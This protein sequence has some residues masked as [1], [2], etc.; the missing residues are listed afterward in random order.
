[1][2]NPRRSG[3][4]WRLSGIAFLM[5]IALSGC[6]PRDWQAQPAERPSIAE[7]TFHPGPAPELPKPPLFE[8]A[9]VDL[10]SAA[11]LKT[12]NELPP[13]RPL[14]QCEPPHG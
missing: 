6:G 11:T 9:E 5:V 13:G 2:I 8:Q 10:Q 1:M 3:L 7:P 14:P 12:L 4:S